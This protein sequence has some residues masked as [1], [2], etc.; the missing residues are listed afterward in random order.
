MR[1]AHHQVR[2]LEWISD[3]CYTKYNVICVSGTGDDT[4]ESGGGI[5]I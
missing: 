1:L 2:G 3:N 4:D 5:K